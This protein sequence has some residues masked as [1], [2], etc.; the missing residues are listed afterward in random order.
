MATAGDGGAIMSK[1]DDHFFEVFLSP[2]DDNDHFWHEICSMMMILFFL[3]LKLPQ[4]G[5]SFMTCN[6]FNDGD[7]FFLGFW[8]PL[9]EDD[10]FW[11]A[12]WSRKMS[13]FFRF[14]SPLDDNDQFWHE[15]CSMMM[16]LFFLVLKPP[17]WG[18]SFMKCNLLNDDD[19]FFLCFEAPSMKMIIFDMQSA[20]GRWAFLTWDLFNDY[21]TFFLV[22]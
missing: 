10:Q 11:H 2:L 16:I 19:T 17:Q 22:F 6:L 3:V 20:Q 1:E 7:T 15:I 4:W 14:L 5:W 9:N 13:I 18:W 21:D 12:T 8:S